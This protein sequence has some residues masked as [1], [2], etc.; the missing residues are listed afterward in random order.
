VRA[1]A[2]ALVLLA[3]LGCG[4]TEGGRPPSAEA[5][6]FTG[7]WTVVS[8]SQRVTCP[9]LGVSASAPV[10]DDVS[11]GAGEGAELEQPL[12]RS[13]C[14]ITADVRGNT[15]TGRPSDCAFPGDDRGTWS[16]TVQSYTFT[17]SADGALAEERFVGAHAFAVDGRQ[18]SCAVE[19]NATYRRRG[20]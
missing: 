6:R 1:R 10:A 19:R 17:L 15:A 11:W 14:S 3:G 5:A 9:T 18:E 16:W 2:G 13:P 20:R 12:P 7:T 8:G 4:A